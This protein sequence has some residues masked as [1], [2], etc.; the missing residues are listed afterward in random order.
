MG[1]QFIN[2]KREMGKRIGKIK[3]VQLEKREAL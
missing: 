2:D 1:L 3:R